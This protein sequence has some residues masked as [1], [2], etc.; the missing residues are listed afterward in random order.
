MYR[1]DRLAVAAGELVLFSL[2][3]ERIWNTFGQDCMIECDERFPRTSPTDDQR[4]IQSS[5]DHSRH[6]EHS[7][8]ND[9]KILHACSST[10]VFLR[11][12]Q[13]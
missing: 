9:G 7:T 8:P 13:F 5:T 3:R 12:V 11:F 10:R 6:D 1:A 2:G 4:L